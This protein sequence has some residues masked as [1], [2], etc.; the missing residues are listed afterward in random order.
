MRANDLVH[1][2]FIRDALQV[3]LSLGSVQFGVADVSA[4]TPEGCRATEAKC[5]A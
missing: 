4:A 5:A 2:E 3:L 1:Q